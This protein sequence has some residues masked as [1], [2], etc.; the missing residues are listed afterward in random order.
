MHA[1]NRHALAD[2]RF[3][4]ALANGL[5]RAKRFAPANR[6]GKLGL[7]TVVAADCPK[8]VVVDRGQR[9]LDQ[10]LARACGG[11][12][13]FSAFNDVDGFAK[14]VVD[15]CFHRCLAFLCLSYG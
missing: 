2:H 7:V 12:V 1:R 15:C 10:N 3:V 11:G 4:N 14:A 9:H 5:Y 8:V 13:D 6:T